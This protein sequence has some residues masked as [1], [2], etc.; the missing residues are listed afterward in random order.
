MSSNASSAPQRDAA[1]QRSIEE[2]GGHR[3]SSIE[4]VGRRFRRRGTA[5]GDVLAFLSSDDRPGKR[6]LELPAGTGVTTQRI[7]D[8]GYDVVPG[9]LF[10]ESYRFD[11]PQCVKLDMSKRLPFEDESFDYVLCQEGIEHIEAPL[12]FV[13]EC[14]RI[15]RP[16]GR[17]ILT[18]PNVLHM[19][20]RLSYFLIGHRTIRSGLINEYQTLWMRD[21]DNLYHGHAWHWRYF[22]LRYALRLAGFKVRPP[23]CA[24][25]SLFSIL[26][27]IP[28]F[29]FLW[30][31]AKR[32]A[33][34][35]YANEKNKDVLPKAREATDEITSHLLSRAILWGKRLIVIGEKEAEPTC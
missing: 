3:V 34:Q 9:D 33:Q 4:E 11:S 10:P 15:L 26:L 6:L 5:T 12:R 13:R 14:S 28:A 31:A 23:Q 35:G 25:Y 16:G 7:A 1:R 21:G 22:V 2:I 20:A 19:S 8:L 17:L 29:P 27:S 30:L 32:A 24:K 18:T